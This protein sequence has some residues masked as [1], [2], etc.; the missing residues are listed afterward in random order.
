MTPNSTDSIEGSLVKIWQSLFGEAIEIA[1]DDSFFG[2][3]GTSI[4]AVRLVERVQREFSVD[5]KLSWV[6]DDP[7][8]S[9]QAGRIHTQLSAQ[10]QGGVGDF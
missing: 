7:T 4:L 5:F 2:L 8:L 6:L 9:G 10:G 1:R 3:G